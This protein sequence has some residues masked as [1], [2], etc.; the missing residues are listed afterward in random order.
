MAVGWAG[1]EGCAAAAGAAA[2]VAGR[3]CRT[4]GCCCRMLS[5]L[6]TCGSSNRHAMLAAVCVRDR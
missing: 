3:G 4:A 5:R 2:A 1:Q 6:G